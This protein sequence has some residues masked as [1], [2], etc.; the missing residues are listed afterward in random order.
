MRAGHPLSDSPV[1]RPHLGVKCGLND[2]FIV[3]VN[4]DSDADVGDVVHAA[5]ADGSELLIERALL[6]PLLRGEQL[7]R[8]C[9]PPGDDAIVW[10]HAATGAALPRLPA[11]AARW[12]AHWRTQLISR[13]DA[14]HASRWWTLFRTEAA[15][16]DRPRVVWADLGREPRAS[17]L[18]A[19]DARVPLNS[20]YIARCRDLRDADFLAALLNSPLARAWLNAV[21][22]PARGGYRRYFGWTLSL[23]PVPRDWPRA[24]DLLAPIGALA[25]AGDVPS[26]RAL[27][28]ATCDAYGIALRDV[29]PLVSWVCA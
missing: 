2:A 20:C 6:R 18:V 23:L 14:R 7:R 11:H 8:W 28:E 27:L 16:D 10:T 5:A 21:A 25:R 29:E 19:G 22:E 13:A 9:V 4:R 26:E 24:R 17:V 3:R 12:F 1:G 15:R